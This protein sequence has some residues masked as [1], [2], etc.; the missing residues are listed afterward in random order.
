[1]QLKCQIVY[2]HCSNSKKN[3]SGS[4]GQSNCSRHF[5][6]IFSVF[7]LS[8]HNSFIF[9]FVDIAAG[10]YLSC[11][12]LWVMTS[13]LIHWQ[14]VVYRHYTTIDDILRCTTLLAQ[15][16]K[17]TEPEL[18]MISSPINYPA[19]FIHAITYVF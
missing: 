13:V 18:I 11:G 10:F 5:E 14:A 16:S 19:C 12:N 6:M 3:F 7:F 9:F 17:Q 4:F 15:K 8:N 2:A 1:M